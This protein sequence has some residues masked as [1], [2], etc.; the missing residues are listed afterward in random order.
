MT[1]VGGMSRLRRHG[2][3]RPHSTAMRKQFPTR[4]PDDEPQ[5]KAK[6]A[7]LCAAHCWKIRTLAQCPMW[8]TSA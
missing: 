5:T 8:G 2:W 3:R 4:G 7:Y 6:Y 1:I